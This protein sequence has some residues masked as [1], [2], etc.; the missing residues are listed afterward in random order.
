MCRVIVVNDVAITVRINGSILIIQIIIN[1]ISVIFINS[2][3]HTILIYRTDPAYKPKNILLS[4]SFHRAH[5]LIYG[6]QR[7]D[8]KCT[9][10]WQLFG[11]E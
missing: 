2:I 7:K 9:E 6:N 8:K 3:I 1:I 11:V 10:Q 5:W 4:C